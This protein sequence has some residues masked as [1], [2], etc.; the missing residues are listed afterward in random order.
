MMRR[1]RYA[2][3]KAEGHSTTVPVDDAATLTSPVS[4][5]PVGDSKAEYAGAFQ[6]LCVSSEAHQKQPASR[7]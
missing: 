1:N 3:V 2:I 6:S 4:V 7:E 5:Q